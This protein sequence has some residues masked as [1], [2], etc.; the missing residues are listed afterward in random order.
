[1]KK[2]L[3]ARTA[4]L[5]SEN[6]KFNDTGISIA[7]EHQPKDPE[8]R[9]HGLIFAVIEIVGPLSSAEEIAELIIDTLHNEFYK[10][11][12]R[13]SLESFEAS[14]SKINEE[15]A[16][17][18][19][20]G[21]IN[22][23]GKLNAILAVLAD[24]TLH[25]TQSG[26]VEAILYRND[27]SNTISQELAG[28]AINPLRTF[29]NI[30][31]GDLLD[32][33]RIGIF[34][35]GVFYH[36]SREE[37][38]KYVTGF[39]P[40]ISS[41]HLAKLLEENNSARR[42]S[43]II[44][45]MITPEALAN[46]TIGEDKEEEVW[47]S[48]SRG[49]LEAITKSASPIALKMA[50]SSMGIL[51]KI[52][53][54]VAEVIAPFLVSQFEKAKALVLKTKAPKENIFIETREALSNS[55]REAL[56]FEESRFGEAQDNSV[57]QTEQ[58]QSRTPI[59]VSSFKKIATSAKASTKKSLPKNTKM[60]V[61]S[62]FA[63]ILLLLSGISV[64]KKRA[65]Q[66][67]AASEKLLSEA[68]DKFN[69]AEN[70]IILNEN[71]KAIES[72]KEARDLAEKTKKT[73]YFRDDAENLLARINEK[74]DTASGIIKISSE[75]IADLSKETA[76]NTAS[77]ALIGSD[78]Y[79]IDASNGNIFKIDIDSGEASIAL[80]KPDFEG[81]IIS[82]TAIDETTLLAIITDAPKVYTFD[83]KSKDFSEAKVS[84]DGWEKGIDIASFSSNLY[85][86]S[87]YDKTVYKHLKNV[88]GYGKK[89]SYIKDLSSID[90]T[91]IVSMAIDG[92]VYILK[93]DGEILKFISGTKKDFSIKGLP[94]KITDPKKIFAN[95]NV[96][97][98]FVV[99]GKRIIRVNEKDE[100]VNQ[101][102]SDKLNNIDGI[103]ADGE[104]NALY[105]LSGNKIYKVGL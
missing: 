17:I 88:G 58:E 98:L 84:G 70:S 103:Y 4:K 95:A 32:G 83:T 50:K 104:K 46:D 15:L 42:C 27:K 64:Q 26:N 16:N 48:D 31:S 39:H 38:Q 59:I 35:P 89:V 82:S 6:R 60:I 53:V 36:L 86:T 30:A 13:D 74:L 37:T 49:N 68:Q 2:K 80:A 61:I 81:K 63:I 20:Q 1:M 28:D 18:T 12:D 91:D 96:K 11:I 45:E 77:L 71:D 73:K 23:L 55:R 76:K 25:L 75:P 105:I 90:L 24:D 87:N 92:S 22:W 101:Y 7:Y 29:I 99:D 65:E 57:L 72:L 34:S 3:V 44:I 5:L 100:F 56:D 47:I 33:D 69:S 97:G 19:E 43:A 102:T 10:D 51:G 54:F 78:L 41:N 40:S 93:K 14:L 94:E 67:R 79:T 9:K 62:I 8:E 52:F 85:I 21:K 66:S